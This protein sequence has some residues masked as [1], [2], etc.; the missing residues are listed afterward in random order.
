[1]KENRGE[2]LDDL[3]VEFLKTQRAYAVKEMIDKNGL[4]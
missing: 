2:Y 4:Y 3:R 1:M